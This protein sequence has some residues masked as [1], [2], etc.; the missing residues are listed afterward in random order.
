MAAHLTTDKHRR[1][2]APKLPK[3][4]GR[5][6]RAIRE[7][8]TPSWVMATRGGTRYRISDAA[9][10]RGAVDVR[11]HHRRKPH[12]PRR[13]VVRVGAH[14]RARPYRPSY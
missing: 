11:T 10:R 1:N 3:R 8:G 13:K 4:R 14:T 12:G 9:F 5:V 2:A 7:G 6:G